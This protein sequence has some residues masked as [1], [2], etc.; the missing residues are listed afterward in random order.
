MSTDML[1][2]IEYAHGIS[3]SPWS[4]DI[5]NSGMSQ[6]GSTPGGSRGPPPPPPRT[7]ARRSGIQ[8]SDRQHPRAQTA[9]GSEVLL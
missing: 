1:P 5:R 9:M 2:K 7:A 6:M 3:K 4:E 8:G